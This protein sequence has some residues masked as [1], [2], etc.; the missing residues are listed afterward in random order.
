MDMLDTDDLRSLIYE[1]KEIELPADWDRDTILQWY[2]ENKDIPS[3]EIEI[4]GEETSFPEETPI[5]SE[6]E[7]PLN[8][9][10]GAPSLEIKSP[11]SPVGEPLNILSPRSQLA[12]AVQAIQSMQSMKEEESLGQ[13]KVEP[14]KKVSMATQVKQPSPVRTLKPLGKLNLSELSQPNIPRTARAQAQIPTL[15]LRTS[16]TPTENLNTLNKIRDSV[17]TSMEINPKATFQ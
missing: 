10:L 13:Q 17:N 8:I 2:E 1:E 14:I 16:V 4:P 6:F 12:Q 11:K 9:P 7:R 3:E 5:S 15:P